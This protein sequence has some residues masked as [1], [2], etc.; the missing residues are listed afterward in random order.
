VTETL[1]RVVEESRN[2]KVE[3]S[4]PKGAGPL[5]WLPLLRRISVATDEH[6]IPPWPSR[7]QNQ[8]S[9]IRKI[10]DT[11]H[12]G[13]TPASTARTVVRHVNKQYPPAPVRSV[14]VS[15]RTANRRSHREN[16]MY[17][18][19]CPTEP[20]QASALRHARSRYLGPSTILESKGSAIL[21]SPQQISRKRS[22]ANMT[23]VHITR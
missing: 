2:Q 16:P 20:D 19:H 23:S 18:P 22:M 8:R 10:V 9:V 12:A 5:F 3:G 17:M 7:I 6:E 13:V 4:T 1:R 14:P 11:S 15:T 21:Q